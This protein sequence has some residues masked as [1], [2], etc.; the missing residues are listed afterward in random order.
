VYHKQFCDCSFN[1]KLTK[2]CNGRTI[3][4][5]PNLF[6][7]PLLTTVQMFGKTVVWQTTS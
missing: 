1:F 6:S 7:R 4:Y 2:V 3:K 5:K